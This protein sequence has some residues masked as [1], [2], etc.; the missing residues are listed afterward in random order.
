MVQR[1]CK[2]NAIKLALIAEVQPFLS[3]DTRNNIVE[4]KVEGLPTSAQEE[5]KMENTTKQ[6]ITSLK[7]PTWGRQMLLMP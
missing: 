6:W 2:P 3:K 5:L 4:V 7:L 1:K